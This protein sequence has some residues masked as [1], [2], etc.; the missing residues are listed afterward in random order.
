MRNRKHPTGHGGSGAA[1]RLAARAAAQPSDGRSHTPSPTPT[2]PEIS[3]T[4]PPSRRA[5]AKHT[6]VVAL[7]A[8][9]NVPAGMIVSFGQSITGTDSMVAC[10]L[11]FIIFVVAGS[12]L[13][14]FGVNG[15]LC[16]GFG[17]GDESFAP[18]ET[19]NASV[20]Y[21]LT[22]LVFLLELQ[23]TL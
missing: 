2:L 1:S 9:V 5:H 12:L 6:K 18:G 19:M 16:K 3:S 10:V 21:A 4:S 8:D 17:I 20:A 11:A 13:T 7:D 22:V 23:H 14:W 15:D